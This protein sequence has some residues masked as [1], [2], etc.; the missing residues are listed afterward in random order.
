MSSCVSTTSPINRRRLS[1]GPPMKAIQVRISVLMLLRTIAILHRVE[2]A[3]N[4]SQIPV[5]DPFGAAERVLVKAA[6]PEPLSVMVARVREIGHVQ[7]QRP[8]S[9]RKRN[10]LPPTSSHAHML[11]IPILPAGVISRSAFAQWPIHA[12]PVQSAN[13][14]PKKRTS[15]PVRVSNAS[16]DLIFEPSILHR[17]FDTHDGSRYRVDVLFRADDLLFQFVTEFF[18]RSR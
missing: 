10:R 1:R 17:R 16:T 14:V 3:V 11:L 2:R 5:A 12:W 4:G 9:L 7:V 18:V 8:R 6:F 13:R 15:A